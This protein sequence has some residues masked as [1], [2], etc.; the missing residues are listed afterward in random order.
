[1]KVSKVIA[2][3]LKINYIK[4]VAVYKIKKIMKFNMKQHMPKIKTDIILI[5]IV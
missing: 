3:N 4:S 2:I 1:M 5:F